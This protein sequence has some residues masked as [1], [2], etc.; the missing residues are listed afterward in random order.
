MK[1]QELKLI[2][3]F[4][5][6]AY[7]YFF[8]NKRKQEIN[9]CK[10]SNFNFDFETLRNLSHVKFCVILSLCQTNYYMDICQNGV[11]F[12]ALTNFAHYPEFGDLLISFTSIRTLNKSIMKP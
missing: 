2:C 10:G 3:I 4:L 6:A 5:I 9:K 1:F 12:K 7:F 8:T 11:T